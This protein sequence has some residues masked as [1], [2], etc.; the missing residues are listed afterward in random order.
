MDPLREAVQGDFPDWI[1]PETLNVDGTDISL[2]DL[3]EVF[4]INWST[5][6]GYKS[7]VLHGLQVENGRFGFIATSLIPPLLFGLT[8]LGLT[9]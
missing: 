4:E 7:A 6:G 8:G 2:E 1:L 3:Q 9:S 5:V